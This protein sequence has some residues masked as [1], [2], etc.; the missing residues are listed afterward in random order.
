R[1][2]NNLGT[3]WAQMPTGDRAENLGKAIAAYGL[4]LEV[5]TREAHP[6]D[7]ARTRINLGLGYRAR[8][9]LGNGRSDL[10]LAIA[11]VRAAAS[12]FTDGDFPFEYRNHIA[13][14]IEELRTAWL[15]GGHGTQAEFDAI[16]P[17]D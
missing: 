17:A 2:Q 9:D 4:A 11:S 14:T 13:P 8:A 1:T 10:A 6:L 16:P 15:Q 5:R 3:A 12:V 7:W